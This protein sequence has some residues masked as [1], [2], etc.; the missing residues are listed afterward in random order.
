MKQYEIW[1]ARLPEPS[2]ERPVLLLSRNEAYQFLNRFVVAEVTSR[3]RGTPIEVQLGTQEG[4]P[5]LCAANFD[6][7]FTLG[8]QRFLRRMGQLA[9]ER[10]TEVKRALGY[11][12]NWE[13]LISIGE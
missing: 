10:W 6:N 12:F 1:W 3:V 9:P 11:S 2:G 13:E 7:L 4:M 8:G 5:K